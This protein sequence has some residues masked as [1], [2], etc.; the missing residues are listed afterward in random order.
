MLQFDPL[1]I[2]IL[3]GLAGALVGALTYRKTDK[4]DIGADAA[5]RATVDAT[6]KNVDTNT[7]R[8]LDSLE[9]SDIRIR[10]LESDV[11]ALKTYIKTLYKK[12]DEVK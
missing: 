1:W 2:N 8:I 7:Q 6:L 3:C 11:S 10:G 12:F 4:K 9:S 5:W